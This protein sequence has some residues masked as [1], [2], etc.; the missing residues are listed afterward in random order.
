MHITDHTPFLNWTFWDGEADSQTQ[1]EIRVGT[2][3]GLF[4]MWASGA[5]PGSTTSE[6]YGGSALVDGTDYWFGV[7]VYDGY[8]WS[9]WN[10]TLFH[11]N[12]VEAQ[13]PT[14]Q[15]FSDP[16][17][18]ILHITDHTPDL[19]WTFFDNEADSQLEYEIRVGTGPGF[20][21]MWNPGAQVSGANSEIYDGLSLVDN[22]DY[23][24]VIRV[25]DG[26][27]WSQWNEV[28]FHMNGIADAVDLT[29][30]G[31]TDSSEGIMHISVTNP[32]LGWAFFDLEGGDTQQQ[33][34]IKVGTS[35]GASDMWLL[36]PQIGPITSETYAGLPL[37]D[38]TDYWFS[39]RVYD[40][41][42]WS[43]WNETRFHM[44]VIPQAQSLTVSGHINGT[45][46]IMHIV[47]HTPDLAW[48]FFDSEIGNVQAQYE[49]RVGS[50]PGLSDLWS[51]GPQEG[52]AYS[53]VYAGLA[54]I[55]GNDY[56]FEVRVFDGYEWSNWD[57]T[58]FHMNTPPP[59]PTFPISPADDS[60]IPSSPAQTLS[61]GSGGPDAEGD[62]VEFWWYID[63]EPIPVFPY[64]FNDTTTSTSSNPFPTNPA[65]DYYWFVNATD[66]WE[67]SSNVIWNFTT[68][69]I[70]NN[71]PEVI[72]ILVSGFAE[73]TTGIMHLTDHAPLFEW[74]FT[75]PDGGDVQ[76]R[77]QIT[78]GTAP[79]LSDIWA[80]VDQV[81]GAGSETYAGSILMDGKDYWFAIRVYDGNTWSAWNETQFHM[82]SVE[83]RDPTVSGY[84]DATAGIM[85]IIDHTPDLEWTYWDGELDPQQR[86]EIQVGTQSGF[87]DMW[88]FGPAGGP[89]TME[90][91]A[92]SILLDGTDYYFQIRV[93][94]SYE[95]S[96]WTEVL[97]HMNALPP[98]PT[99]PLSPPDDANIPSSPAQTLSW[100]SGGPDQ[101]GDPVTF[102]WY[103][104]TDPIPSAPYIAEGITSGFSSSSF[105]TSPATDF[106]WFINAT[107][108]WE[109]N[110]TIIWNFTTS[111]I[112]NNP[113]E[114]L[115]LTVS[116]YA[117]GSTGIMHIIDHT[118][119]FT[120]S[121]LDIDGGDTQQQYEIG[122]GTQSG[123]SD[124]WTIG[125]QSG[126]ISMET[127]NGLVLVDGT[128]YFFGIRL[129]D[130][131]TWSIW[132][133]TLF[134]MNSVPP[135]P[136]PLNPPDDA[137]IPDSPAQTL[138]WT[139]GGA[140]S[141][142][143]TINYYWYI[144][145]DSTPTF[146]YLANGTTTGTSSTS[147][148]TAPGTG[149]YW[150][151]NVTDGWEWNSTIVWN[152][153]TSGA[154]NIP[155]EVLDL[156]V[157]G[158]ADGTQGIL[159]IT[160]STP[161]LS[162]NFSDADMG[163][164]QI[165][166]EIRVGTASGLSDMWN[167]GP[168][169]GGAVTDVYAGTPLLDGT[170]YW[171]GVLI[172]DGVDWSVINETMFHMNSLPEAHGLTVEGY[173]DGSVEIMHL[174]IHTPN[175][176]W[177][178]SDLEGADTQTQY[179]IRV[180][181]ASGLA[182][183]WAPGP[184]IG[185]VNSEVYGG[186][187]L[188]DGSD[189][190]LGIM[191]FDGYEWSV[192]NETQLHMNTPPPTAISPTVPDNG[193]QVAATS[194]QTL[195]WTA[196]GADVEGDTITYHWFVDT[197][198]PLKLPYL[199]DNIT[200]GTSSTT[201]ITLP[202]SE[203][204]WFVNG[205]DGWEWSV[206]IVWNF[207]TQN[208]PNNPPEARDLTVQG[209]VDGTD[210]LHH[211]LEHTPSLAWSFFDSDSGDSQMRYEI[212]VGTKSRSSNMW[213]PGPVNGASSEVTYDGTFL[214][215]GRDYFFGVRVFDGEH[216]S[217]W[218]EVRFHMN[219]PPEVTELTVDGFAEGTSNILNISGSNP[220][221]G[222]SFQD[223]DGGSP[224]LQYEIRIGTAQGLSD[225][226]EPGIQ[227]RAFSEVTYSGPDLSEG[228][229]Y[230]YGLRV[231][232]GYEWSG[233]VDVK[234]RTNALPILDWTGDSGYTADG[235]DPEDGNLS[236]T[237][238]FLVKYSDI[239]GH[240]PVVGY[241]KVHIFKWGLE[242]VG[243]PFTMNYVC[244]SNLTGAIYSLEITLNEGMNYSYYFSA[245][246]I[247]GMAAQSTEIK[248]GPYVIDNTP[249]P[250]TTPPQ[251]V[252]VIPTDDLGE[253][254]I[255]W[256]KSEDANVDGYHIYR[257]TT[258]FDTTSGIDYEP[259]RTVDENT[260]SF[261]DSDLEDETTYYYLIKGF[262][263]HG[264]ESDYSQEVQGTTL[265]MPE[266][267]EEE[268]N[269]L[270]I[271]LL[272]I[273]IIV[274]ILLLI[275]AS[276]RG[277]RE[278]EEPISPEE[279]YG[280][281]PEDKTSSIKE[282]ESISKEDD[283]EPLGDEEE[284][285]PPSYDVPLEGKEQIQSQ[286]YKE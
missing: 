259:V 22:T 81:S 16:S 14:V 120:W 54:L 11:V 187:A 52:A 215:D 184:Q 224:P 285:N 275:I 156:S 131:S 148:A 209:F 65:T 64:L 268:D 249:I 28:Q 161:D 112:V 116:G 10:E 17:A 213:N 63:T 84:F 109:W 170:D 79:G 276:K 124:M 197:E 139:P 157:S 169:A 262:D 47:D 200:T 227:N 193:S 76:Q 195:S 246:D 236:T 145:T 146:P 140:D 175:L 43:A 121:F 269:F 34:E 186:A 188:I 248:N 115:D 229:H 241:P 126:A 286:D 90:V 102:Y 60:N 58:Q 160:D 127:Y 254:R 44:N 3:P 212:R 277:R 205:T 280:D 243:S 73:G 163:D 260:T 86:Y 141:E 251:D 95:W 134:H 104:D 114:A 123:F 153:T 171:F 167:P 180:G 110:P 113:P 36:P 190:W 216:W 50:A 149:Y 56:W 66:G 122:V 234:F 103:I 164:I 264:V 182:D 98:L 94:D 55:D 210:D 201:F 272:I 33:Y 151:I 282:K 179:E 250:P 256:K 137:N 31:F 230:W 38:G 87:S 189:Y 106:H 97:F 19:G 199:T 265:A 128:D 117:N 74:S 49:I 27:E 42:E 214:E 5:M 57:E 132:N 221:L 177:V 78:V 172:Y 75:D 173:S 253:L 21:D 85:H 281:S 13:D 71:P 29:V 206:S 125:P 30:D 152:F 247:L 130:G 92:G 242:I 185:S 129:F 266:E 15:G 191:V 257:S 51:P 194:S 252:T 147:F 181:T 150:I 83:A 239:D 198:F 263:S 232:D 118:P 59:L 166:Y 41:F 24:F 208:P 226:W 2:A 228:T 142:G 100:T 67:W 91:Y 6:I 39:V 202:S 219:E 279:L 105:P 111:A 96:E 136:T 70:V 77:Y 192:W 211:L 245:S 62:I 240:D 278:E 220:E 1:Y 23:W 174:L 26:Y 72:D 178:F 12:S 159:H 53:E 119:D 35:S 154:V 183:M 225:V 231:F 223:S 32:N 283:P 99:T 273:I 9:L 68:S 217:A 82:N 222:G 168:Q 138:S 261:I 218:N 8:E 25:Y 108:S 237:F 270:W 271:L 244:G 93:N 61:W 45:E 7:R 284:L 165:Q 40:G 204:Y 135:I 37:V 233:W 267:E 101:E 69:A 48:T 144:D 235:L 207:T 4:N 89:G 158:F 196:G 162:W 107:D 20:S 258:S 238:V 143:D 18:G 155:P 274:L 46:G 133:E 88:V 203:Y 176:S 255:T 80:P